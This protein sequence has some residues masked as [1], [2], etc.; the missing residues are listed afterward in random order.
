VGIQGHGT[1]A[2]LF[3]LGSNRLVNLA[4]QHTAYDVERGL[5]GVAATL[6]ESRLE[7]CFGHGPRDGRPP[8][9]DH[10]RPHADGLHKDDVDQQVGEGFGVLHHTP[11]ELNDGNAVAKAT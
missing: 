3:D 1:A 4:C 2:E 8:A 11:A 9:V 7:L 5:V 6:D 10:D